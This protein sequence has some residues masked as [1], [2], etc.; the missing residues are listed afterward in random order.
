MLLI[1]LPRWFMAMLKDHCR[2]K[3]EDF[4]LLGE[5]LGDNAGYMFSEA[6]LE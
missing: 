5:V 3:K 1:S 6:H 2:Q 4:F